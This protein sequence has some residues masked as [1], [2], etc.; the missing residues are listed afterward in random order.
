[1][2]VSHIRNGVELEPLGRQNYYDWWYQGT[3]GSPNEVGRKLLPGDRL[4][5]H[6]YYDTTNSLSWHD[7][8]GTAVQNSNEIF[9]LGEGTDDEMCFNFIAYYP[10]H[11]DLKL[12][13][14]ATMGVG[15]PTESFDQDRRNLREFSSQDMEI[16]RILSSANIFSEL[17]NGMMATRERRDLTTQ[18]APACA[19]STNTMELRGCF[20]TTVDVRCA[21]GT[22][23]RL[24]QIASGCYAN[25]LMCTD[26]GTLTSWVHWYQN[27]ACVPA[28][29]YC[30]P[31]Y[32]H[33]PCGGDF[34]FDLL[35][36]DP[37]T[38]YSVATP[39]SDVQ[40]LM[41]EEAAESSSSGMSGGMIGGII[42]AVVAVVVVIAIAFAVVRHQQPGA[43]CRSGNADMEMHNRPT[44]PPKTIVPVQ[45]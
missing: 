9:G 16:H 3:S 25:N 5:T 7:R 21:S 24:C 39:S 10:R 20:D 34:H 29:T 33:S 13:I 36:L 19:S 23:Q 37:Y 38:P 30:A 2:Y 27:G 32:P 14:G 41:G 12:C 26:S 18:P 45:L 6:C 43:S 22:I 44:T 15:D 31:C 4:I 8:G 40:C 17:L 1:M 35:E 28:F 42:A 11:N